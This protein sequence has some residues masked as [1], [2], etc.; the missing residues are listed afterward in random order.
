M[1]LLLRLTPM[2]LVITGLLFFTGCEETEDEVNP[3]VGTWDIASLDQVVTAI[4]A[5]SGFV[6]MS[7]FYGPN[8]SS[9]RF[10]QAGDTLA[11]ATVVPWA[12]FE[13]LGVTGS[14]TMKADESFTLSGNL[15]LPSDT[16][17]VAPTAVA[18]SDGGTWTESELD[19]QP[20]LTI[21]GAFYDLGGLMD[22]SDDENTITLTYQSASTDSMVIPVDVGVAVL[23]DEIEV[24]MVT[25]GVLVFTRQ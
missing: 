13:A 24:T 15:P 20:L 7:A 18:L 10:A 9:V 19:G 16:L 12:T 2:L 8:Y 5:D 11:D 3:L 6:D 14:V 22:L 25:Q 21:D 23:Y 17:G 1:K 4:A